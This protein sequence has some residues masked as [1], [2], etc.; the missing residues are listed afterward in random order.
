MEQS[1]VADLPYK[2]QA[3]LNPKYRSL[4]IRGRLIHEQ[5][6]KSTF[7]EKGKAGDYNLDLWLDGS[8]YPMDPSTGKRP[9]FYDVKSMLEFVGDGENGLLGYSHGL[10]N[11]NTE[12]SRRAVIDRERSNNEI[13][14]L[15]KSLEVLK[16]REEQLEN[17]QSVES[18]SLHKRIQHLQDLN[19]IVERTFNTMIAS[20]REEIKT[21]TNELEE[22]IQAEIEREAEI[23][24]IE[25]EQAEKTRQLIENHNSEL[26]RVRIDH[27]Q[28]SKALAV[29]ERKWQKVQST[30]YGCRKQSR[31]RRDLHSLSQSGGHAKALRRLARSIVAPAT[32]RVVQESNAANRIK[33]RLCG[34]MATQVESGKVFAS[35]LSKTEVS[36][37]LQ[38][39]AMESVGSDI[40]NRYLNKIG[41]EIGA[42][43]ILAVEDH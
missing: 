42:H 37:I 33:Q 43:E 32:V 16:Q 21:I 24:A 28:T 41:A 4:I 8:I 20:L 10:Q 23:K 29:L 39:P 25:K 14:D 31:I 15:R 22:S 19:I 12:I 7:P 27:N 35:I 40:T 36:T 18:E 17:R 34:S 6:S 13:A 5:I 1:A 26:E 30:P 38:M 11:S 9:R 3:S 2:I